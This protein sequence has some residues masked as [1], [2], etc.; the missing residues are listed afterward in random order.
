MTARA[1]LARATARLEQLNPN[2]QPAHGAV[3]RPQRECLPLG[4]GV[5]S[6]E[7]DG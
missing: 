7:N 3:Q 4:A 6:K 1:I 5:A 2:A